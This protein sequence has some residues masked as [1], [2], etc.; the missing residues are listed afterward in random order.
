M[1]EKTTVQK[2]IEEIVLKTDLKREDLAYKLREAGFGCCLAT[3]HKWAIGTGPAKNSVGAIA[4]ALRKIL[5]AN[6]KG[7][8]K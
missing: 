6:R 3:L 4:E 5:K 1:A 8:R 2:L 7:A